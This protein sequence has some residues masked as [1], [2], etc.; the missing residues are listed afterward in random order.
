MSDILAH[1]RQSLNLSAFWGKRGTLDPVVGAA[2]TLQMSLKQAPSIEVHFEP[3]EATSLHCDLHESGM[4][5]MPGK[6]WAEAPRAAG[7]L[8]A[9]RD[10]VMAHRGQRGQ[11]GT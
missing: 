10:V 8:L 1:S 3:R 5:P 4:L 2:L 11:R 7:Q 9:G 6:D